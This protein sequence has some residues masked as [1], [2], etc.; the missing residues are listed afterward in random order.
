M[1]LEMGK[2]GHLIAIKILFLSNLSKDCALKCFHIWGYHYLCQWSRRKSP[3]SRKKVQKWKGCE[4]MVT[5]L[6]YEIELTKTL[7]KNL[8]A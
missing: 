6:D 1:D 7:E 2:R 5:K 3:K 4:V 8:D